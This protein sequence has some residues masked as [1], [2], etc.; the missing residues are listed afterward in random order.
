MQNIWQRLNEGGVTAAPVEAAA[1]LGDPQAIDPYTGGP[2]AAHGA[3]QRYLTGPP[4]GSL[5]S[6]GSPLSYGSNAGPSAQQYRQAAANRG[7]A[8]TFLQ[9]QGQDPSAVQQQLQAVDSSPRYNKRQ[10]AALD[11][12]KQSSPYH[13]D[14]QKRG[15]NVAEDGVSVYHTRPDGSRDFNYSS[16]G[17]YRGAIPDQ[18]RNEAGN[19]NTHDAHFNKETGQW[20]QGDLSLMQTFKDIGGGFKDAYGNIRNTIP[21]M[22]QEVLSAGKDLVSGFGGGNAI[23]GG[24][25]DGVGNWGAVGDFFGGIG[26]QIGVTDYAGQA[27][28]KQAVKQKRDKESAAQK[29]QKAA[30]R[31]SLNDSK[32]RKAQKAAKGYSGGYGFNDGGPVRDDDDI[33]VAASQVRQAPLSAPAPAGGGGIA[34][35]G[36][37]S[38]LMDIGMKLLGGF[39]NDG[40]KVNSNPNGYREGGPLQATP[41][42]KEM[43]IDKMK[44]AREA[45]ERK[46]ARADELHQQAMA[47]KEKQASQAMTMKKEAATMK[48]P[49]SGSK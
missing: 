38:P 6:F 26:D 13:Q 19:A 7:R 14:L 27:A 36:G 9:N 32:R 35:S 21:L 29:K 46:E 12:A 42:K 41:I 47:I 2:R 15:L 28:E 10:Q 18:F 25:A 39:F 11:L 1:P 20:E 34:S 17:Q 24:G 4:A 45:F 40:G 33:K 30:N 5:Q 37:G 48:A 49:L 23:S 43:D 16:D 8:R 31:A 22:G 3:I 44:M